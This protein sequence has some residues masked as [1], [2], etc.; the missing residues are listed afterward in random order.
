MENNIMSYL[1]NDQIEFKGNAVDAFN[2]LKVSNPFTLFD[3]QQR[4]QVSDKWDY[5][6]FTGGT[7]SYNITESTVSLTSGLTSGSKLYCE[8]KKVFPYQ[9]G[10]SLTIINTFAMAQPK[11]GLRQRVGYFGITGGV[12]SGSPYNGVYLEQNGLTLSICLASGSLGTTQTITQSNWNTDKFD[13]TGSS[14]VTIDVTKGNIFWMDVEWLGVGDVRTG[15][16]ID[17]RPIVAHVFRNVNKNSTTY[18]TTACLPLRYEIE[19]TAGQ[20]G[21]STLRQICST[22]LSES[23]YEGFSRRFN[24]TKNGSNPTTLTT[25]DVQYPMVALRLNRNRLDS[26][27]I[28]SNVSVV[29]EPGTNNKPVTVQYRILLNPTLTGNTWTTHY[30]GNVDYNITATAVT[31]GTDIIGGY[32]SSSG[33]F[34]ISDIRDFNFQ[35]GRTQ[36]GASDVFALTCTPIEDGTNVFVDLSWCEII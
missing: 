1:F 5:V 4:Y 29:V 8:T 35:I 18:M 22:V 9:P 2:R 36:T 17:G 32:I 25:Q 11:T 26:I 6:G 23:G 24:I 12:T 14:G 15:F 31:G 33:S 21:S 10:K 19:N 7:Y 20:T 3:S 13:G 27:I 30:N 16:F 34:S 28:P